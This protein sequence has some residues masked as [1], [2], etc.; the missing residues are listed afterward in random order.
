LG[1]HSEI[2]KLAYDHSTRRSNIFDVE[3]SLDSYVQQNYTTLYD[4]I[5]QKNLAAIKMPRQRPLSLSARAPASAG[6]RAAPTVVASPDLVALA[7]LADPDSLDASI[8]HHAT[9]PNL[10][11]QLPGLDGSVEAE[12][13]EEEAFNGDDLYEADSDEEASEDEE[14]EEYLQVLTPEISLRMFEADSA[15]HIQRKQLRKDELSSLYGLLKKIVTGDSINRIKSHRRYQEAVTT[16]NGFVLWTIIY[17]THQ[18]SNL[19]LSE[20]QER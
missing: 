11:S 20:S 3:P 6:V 18:N 8:L 2:P 17:S 10:T 16:R 5:L 12:G 4:C 19:Y 15:H 14:E 9:P 7:A 13:D 1:S